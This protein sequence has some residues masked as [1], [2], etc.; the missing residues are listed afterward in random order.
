MC[1]MEGQFWLTALYV[2]YVAAAAYGLFHW[3]GKGKYIN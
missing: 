3:L 1:F 2:G